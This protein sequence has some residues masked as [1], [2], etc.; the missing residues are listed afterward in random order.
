MR[1]NEYLP[2]SPFKVYNDFLIHYDTG[3]NVFEEKPTNYTNFGEILKYEIMFTQHSG[4]YDFLNVEKLVDEFMLNV[5]NRVGK[6]NSD[7]FIKCGFS[8]KNIQPLPIEKEQP[9]RN[10]KY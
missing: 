1:C 3:K 5:K 2:G 4:N 7:L 6:S 9:I 10:S 8:L